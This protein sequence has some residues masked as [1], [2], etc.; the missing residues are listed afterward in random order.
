MRKG[1]A[2]RARALPSTARRDLPRRDRRPAAVRENGGN[3]MHCQKIP[4]RFGND[5]FFRRAAL[6]YD[7]SAR[8]APHAMPHAIER[9][10]LRQER[11]SLHYE[12][13]VHDIHF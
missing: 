1:E 5:F 2:G 10:T 4:W 12:R 9:Q 13:G 8:R 3:L 6:R 11:C 7:G